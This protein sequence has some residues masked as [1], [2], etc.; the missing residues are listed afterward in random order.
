MQKLIVANF[1][2]NGNVN[3]YNQVNDKFN[4]L[5][6]KDTVILCPPFVYMPFLKIKNKF[7]RYGSQDVSNEIN[8]KSTGNISPTMLKEF[9]A[10][11]SIVGHSERRANGET[12]TLV[13][14]K[15]KCCVENEICPVVC[16][17]EKTKKSSI[18]AI[19]KQVQIAVSEIKHTSNIIFAYE[20]VWAIGS[21]EIPTNNKINKVIEIIKQT[22]QENGFRGIKVLYGGSV[23]ENNY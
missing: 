21:G 23:N 22:L 3:F 11:Y 4:S 9:N 15:V 1:K 8:T 6:L 18:S 14:K 13:A 12:D 19:K 20:P 16:V 7:V 10:G 17:G 2:M 5:K